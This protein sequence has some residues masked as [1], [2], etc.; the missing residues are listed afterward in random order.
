MIK[1][2]RVCSILLC[3]FIVFPIAGCTNKLPD[4]NGASVD[5]PS[6]AYIQMP[7]PII[8]DEHV[9]QGIKQEDIGVK[10][11]FIAQTPKGLSFRLSNNSG[12]DIK[13]GDGHS[14]YYK[15]G[16]YE[17][18]S[19]D[20]FY[21]LRS[22]KQQ[23]IYADIYEIGFG[24]FQYVVNIIIDPN[25]KAK[26]KEYIVVAD[27]AIENTDISPSLT[28]VTMEVDQDFASPIGIVINVTNGLTDG[29]LYYDKSFWI[30][31]N[32]NGKWEDVAPIASNA[33]LNDTNF[34]G[35]RQKLSDS[36]YWGWLYGELAPGEYRFGKSFLHRNKEGQDTQYDIYSTFSLDGSPIPEDVE[37][38]DEETCSNPFHSILTRKGAVI[39]LF[40]PDE[41]P[42]GNYSS[43]LRL[44][45]VDGSVRYSIDEMF[46]VYSY[47]GLPVLDSNG[48]HIRFTDI[49]VGSIIEITHCGLYMLSGIPIMGCPFMIKIIE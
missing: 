10:L 16:G 33:F 39:K 30:Q 43:G 18:S 8:V 41:N 42:I 17:G 46:S 12:Y 20:E 44:R 22:G 23:I 13:Y 31:R 1:L 40:G 7:R 38:G 3:L 4:D 36:I 15:R 28:T 29:F 27:F 45:G 2:R 48:N 47:F 37:K 11:V 14:L 25:N 32:V 5:K 35:P 6:D 26:A 24:E 49:E 9:Q 34:L 21:V 19:G